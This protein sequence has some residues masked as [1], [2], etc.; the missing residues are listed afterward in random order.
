M[1]NLHGSQCH[2][3]AA[4]LPNGPFFLYVQEIPGSLLPRHGALLEKRFRRLLQ[5]E[6]NADFA[7]IAD[8]RQG[9]RAPSAPAQ[10]AQRSVLFLRSKK[11]EPAFL[12]ALMCG[13]RCLV[14]YVWPWPKVASVYGSGTL[15]ATQLSH[16]SVVHP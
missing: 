1:G 11:P 8:D 2:L 4:D 6:I 15:T 7:T 13:D 12:R 16:H 9:N 5:R 3:R 10:V 14:F